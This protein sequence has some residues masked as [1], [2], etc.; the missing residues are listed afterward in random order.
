MSVQAIVLLFAFGALSVGL[1][2]FVSLIFGARAEQ[3][4]IYSVRRLRVGAVAR[5]PAARRQKVRGYERHPSLKIHTRQ[6]I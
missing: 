1:V 6:L 4:G 2:S 5:R 3:G